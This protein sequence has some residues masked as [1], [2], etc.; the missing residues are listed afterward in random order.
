MNEEIMRDYEQL[1]GE[2]NELRSN[3]N[4]GKDE[5]KAEMNAGGSVEG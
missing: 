4:T 1:K 5:M 3:P 2:N